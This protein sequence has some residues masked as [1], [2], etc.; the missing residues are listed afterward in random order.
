MS[1]TPNR[2][3]ASCRRSPSRSGSSGGPLTSSRRS[4]MVSDSL[5]IS[6]RR[7]GGLKTAAFHAGGSPGDH[8]RG[9]QRADPGSRGEL[10]FRP[11]IPAAMAGLA[12]A[13][14]AAGRMRNPARPCCGRAETFRVS[15]DRA[16]A[17]RSTAPMQRP[18]AR[19]ETVGANSSEHFAE[20]SVGEK[21]SEARSPC[22][23]SAPKVRTACP[24][25]PAP[26]TGP[27]H[28]PTQGEFH[29][30]QA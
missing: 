23:T 6:A 7:C 13:G 12:V 17:N 8:R 25:G 27:H 30:C 14:V 21:T 5:R 11:F 29:D 26:L 16:S 9:D 1:R 22:A 24:M 3:P 15:L 10:I 28:T 20:V 4:S 2:S 18:N 19:C